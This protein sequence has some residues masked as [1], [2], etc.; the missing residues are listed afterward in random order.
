MNVGCKLRSG[1]LNVSRGDGLFMRARQR[2]EDDDNRDP[3]D[4]DDLAN[5]FAHCASL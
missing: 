5:I 4:D 1:N 2:K 3:D